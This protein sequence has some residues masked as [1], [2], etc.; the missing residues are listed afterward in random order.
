[1]HNA[2]EGI[3]RRVVDDPQRR[4]AMVEAMFGDTVLLARITPD[5]VGRLALVPGAA[6]VA[7]V[8]STSVDVLTPQ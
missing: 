1:M 2:L 6:V 4:A 7:L 3:V 5:A 8:K